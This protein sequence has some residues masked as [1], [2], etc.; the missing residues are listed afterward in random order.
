MAKNP[1]D[2]AAFIKAVQRGGVARDRAVSK[3]YEQFTGYA[4]LALKQHR[5]SQEQAFDAY[6]DA[7]QAI[8][9][10]VEAGIYREEAQL[11]S[12]LFKILKLRLIDSIRGESTDKA[13]AR[14]QTESEY[15]EHLQSPIDTPEQ[16]SINQDLFRRLEHI[17][18]RAG[19]HC[20]EVLM[21]MI[22]FGYSAE[23]TA[24][25]VGLKNAGV[26][27]VTKKKCLDKATQLA[28]NLAA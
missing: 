20:R 15:P 23:E 7:V 12:L 22:Y 11:A 4:W 8:T 19:T 2:Q 13:Q 3:L 17:L 9:H 16:R 6:R 24:Q 28:R 25:R 10:Q 5:V 27:R 1:F 26:V 21:S 18:P 14:R